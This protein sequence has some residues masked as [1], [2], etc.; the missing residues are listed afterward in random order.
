MKKYDMPKL[1]IL[2]FEV[3]DILLTSVNI[4]ESHDIG[5]GPFDLDM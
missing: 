5:D 2:H 1:E 3:N 4:D